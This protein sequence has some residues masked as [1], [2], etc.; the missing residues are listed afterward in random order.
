MNK[1][2]YIKKKTKVGVI[3]ISIYHTHYCTFTYID[4]ARPGNVAISWS[5]LV[6]CFHMIRPR[7]AFFRWELFVWKSGLRDHSEPF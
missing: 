1:C 5:K 2:K 6:S 3:V 7:K 4:T